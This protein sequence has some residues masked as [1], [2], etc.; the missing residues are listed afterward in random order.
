MDEEKIK[1]IISNLV[2]ERIKELFVYLVKRND[3]I[4]EKFEYINTGITELRLS[5]FDIK[6]KFYNIE[7]AEKINKYFKN[8]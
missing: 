6:G 1:S 4:E 5:M 3:T 7:N 8:N 2:D